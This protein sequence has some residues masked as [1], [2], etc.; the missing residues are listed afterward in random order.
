[1]LSAALDS[2][3]LDSSYGAPTLGVYVH[4]VKFP[5]KFNKILVIDDL[6][7]G[8]ITPFTPSPDIIIVAGQVVDGTLSTRYYVS[9]TQSQWS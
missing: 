4:R 3:D 7:P 6:I 2:E 1:M 5:A 9:L 8:Q